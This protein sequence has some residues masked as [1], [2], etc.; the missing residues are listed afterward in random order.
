MRKLIMILLITFASC[1]SDRFVR[2]N[3]LSNRYKMKYLETEKIARGKLKQVMQMKRINNY[4]VSIKFI[5]NTK[6]SKETRM[7]FKHK[8]ELY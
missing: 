1:S 3:D 6:I 7:L 5:K 2:Y 8:I 4:E